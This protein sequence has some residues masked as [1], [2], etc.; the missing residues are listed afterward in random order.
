[1]FKEFPP[2]LADWYLEFKIEKSFSH[3]REKYSALQRLFLGGACVWYA[4]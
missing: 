1:M 3:S 2:F 4:D